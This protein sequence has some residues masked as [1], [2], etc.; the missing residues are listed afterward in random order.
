MYFLAALATLSL[1]TT[2]ALL[3]S[4]PLTLSSLLLGDAI[5]IGA[6][7]ELLPA[8]DLS[9]EVALRELIFLLRSLLF[10]QFILRPHNN[11]ASSL[12]RLLATLI[13]PSLLFRLFLPSVTISLPHL[14]YLCGVIDVIT[15][16]SFLQE[17]IP[18]LSDNLSA[19][20]LTCLAGGSLLLPRISYLPNDFAISSRL[21]TLINLKTLSLLAASVSTWFFLTKEI[22]RL[23]YLQK[24]A[25]TTVVVTSSPTLDSTMRASYSTPPSA[26]TS[27]PLSSS[28]PHRTLTKGSL[29]TSRRHVRGFS[30]SHRSSSPRP[31]VE[32]SFFVWPSISPFSPPLPIHF[33]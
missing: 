14:E 9:E 27:A 33:S 4:R 20:V 11:F 25:A 31:V 19:L 12:S 29:R 7:V 26:T 21:I 1:I 8:F 15:F 16:L 5:I 24:P 32:A 13:L 23:R 22:Y 30:D 3:R 28:A 2:C 10:L 18:P 6:I 17:E